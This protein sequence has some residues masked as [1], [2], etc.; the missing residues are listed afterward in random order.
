MQSEGVEYLWACAKGAYRN[1]T[2]RQKK[3]KD[4]LKASVRHCLSE[5]V[6]TKV[7]IRKFARQA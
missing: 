3:G 6:I 2:L 7:R 4:N 5:D 1:M